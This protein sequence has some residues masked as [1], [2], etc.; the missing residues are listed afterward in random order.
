MT[1]QN[2]DRL[3]SEIA[4]ALSSRGFL[5]FHSFSRNPGSVPVIAW[6]THR[7]A[8]YR[9]FLDVARELGTKLMNFHHREFQA[10]AIDLAF[11]RL[12]EAEMD[13]EE[14]Q[15]LERKLRELRVYEGLTCSIELS[16]DH[17][18]RMYLFRLMS[19]WYG[20]FLNVM[21]EIDSYLPE[22]TYEDEEEDEEP[23]GGYYSRN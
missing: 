19:D 18:G 1:K 8:D 9:P 4:D 13:A 22:E 11:D 20:E 3:R 17:E 10:A 6:D 12:E 15:R 23:L 21:D 2:L 14:R 16:F 7:S 5:V